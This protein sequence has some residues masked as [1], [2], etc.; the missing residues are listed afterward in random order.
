MRSEATFKFSAVS[1]SDD[2]TKHTV[3]ADGQPMSWRA[4]I[5]ALQ[6]EQD[7]RGALTETIASSQFEQAYWETPALSLS[8]VDDPFEFVLVSAHLNQRPNP[9]AFTEFLDA[10]ELVATFPNLGGDAVLISPV[11]L[12]DAAERSYL[13]PFMRT[14]PA[15]QVD[16]F[17]A[18]VGTAIA[19]RTSDQPV[20]VSTAGGGVPWLHCR[21]DDRPKYY[22]HAPYRNPPAPK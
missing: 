17:W 14:A 19:S 2:L 3:A 12:D 5:G 6:N 9:A 22:S 4:V 1:K 20:W 18:A 21:L 8:S 11:D 13:L 16:Q 7:F 10:A 15:N